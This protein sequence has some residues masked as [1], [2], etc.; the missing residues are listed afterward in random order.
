MDDLCTLLLK[1]SS[2]EEMRLLLQDL[3]TAQERESIAE[4][5]QILKLIKNGI[6]QRNVQ[7]QLKVSISKVTRGSHALKQKKSIVKK[8]L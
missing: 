1:A 5:V 6:S 7:Q 4:R 8:W 2:Q 3:L